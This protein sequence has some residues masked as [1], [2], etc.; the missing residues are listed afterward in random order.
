V[1]EDHYVVEMTLTAGRRDGQEPAV[2]RIGVD[3]Y[4]FS[5]GLITSKRSYLLAS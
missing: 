2:R 3:V 5:D 1:G 4:T